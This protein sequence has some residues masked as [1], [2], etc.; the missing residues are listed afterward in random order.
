MKTLLTLVLVVLISF[1]V[2]AQEKA[3]S[4]LNKPIGQ[5]GNLR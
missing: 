2:K 1:G 3:S 4:S 5:K